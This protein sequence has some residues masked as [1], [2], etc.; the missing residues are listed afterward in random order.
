MLV[1]KMCKVFEHSFFLIENY[2]NNKYNKYL[3]KSY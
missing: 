1:K 3:S 2:L